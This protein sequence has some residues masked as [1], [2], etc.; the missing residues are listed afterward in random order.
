[1]VAISKTSENKITFIESL[2]NI[3]VTLG[4]IL[5]ALKSTR[6]ENIEHA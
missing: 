5:L 2:Y 4:H 6:S 3:H 1:M